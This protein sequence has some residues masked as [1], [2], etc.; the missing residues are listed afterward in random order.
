MI[1]SVQSALEYLGQDIPED[2]LKRKIK[3]M[4]LSLIHI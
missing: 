3:A 1:V 2:V 4:E